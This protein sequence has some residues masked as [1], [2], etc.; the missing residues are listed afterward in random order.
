MSLCI[1]IERSMA[2]RDEDIRKFRRASEQ[3][4]KAA[5]LLFEH[6]FYLEAIYIGGYAIECTLKQL[7]LSRT[8]RNQ[9]RLMLEKLT[10][11]GA[12][13]HDF[14]YLRGILESP[15]MNCF[16]PDDVAKLLGRVSTW[17]TELRY[18][19]G[20]MKFEEADRFLK[21]VR[22]VRDWAERS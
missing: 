5:E 4:L 2:K 6:A 17:S 11:V 18:E 10:K 20:A 15:P 12:K 1:R 8:P 14:E 9:H 7:I 22:R 3:R 21:G 16:P 13:G 19:V